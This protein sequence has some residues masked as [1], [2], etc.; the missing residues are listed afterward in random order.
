LV[1]ASA[2]F[3]TPYLL[4]SAIIVTLEASTTRTRKQKPLVCHSATKAPP[5]R[6]CFYAIATFIVAS[7]YYSGASNCSEKKEEG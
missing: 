6:T 4:L 7:N 3:A 2:M 1:E 5:G